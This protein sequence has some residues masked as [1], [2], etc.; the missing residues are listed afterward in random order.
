VRLDRNF[1]ELL[2]EL[3]VAQTGV[4]ILF[5]FLLGVA[6]TRPFQASDEVSHRVF[7]VTLVLCAL[8]TA[9]LIAPVAVHRLVFGQRRKAS[10]IRV[11]SVLATTGLFVLATA[12]A[13]ALLLALDAVLARTTAIAVTSGVGLV[14]IL[15]WIVLP[16]VVRRGGLA[17]GRSPR[18]HRPG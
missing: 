9:L 16:L 4:Q 11:G 12:I 14:F 17:R 7:T 1:E 5:A 2:Q 6:F 18:P 10:L 13:G 8:A 3:R 15:L